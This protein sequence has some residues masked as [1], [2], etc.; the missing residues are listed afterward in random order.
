M[1]ETQAESFPLLRYA[2]GMHPPKVTETEVRAVIRGLTVGSTLPSGAAVRAALATCFGSRGGVTRIY[3]ILAEE[4]NRLSPPP[5]PGS[6]EALQQEVQRLRE[7]LARTQERED[8]HQTHWAQEVDRLRQR[9]AT[10]E[11]QA[12]PARITRDAYELLRHQVQAA[13][14]RAARFEEQLLALTQGEDEG[15]AHFGGAAEAS[16]APMPSDCVLE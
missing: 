2:L 13:E 6:V 7:Q 16:P 3:R 11:P 12:H 4:R 5:E 15:R 1:V 9:I 10:Q 8:A 14:L